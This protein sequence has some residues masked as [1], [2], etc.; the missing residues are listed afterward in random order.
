MD[1]DSAAWMAYIPSIRAMSPSQRVGLIGSILL[2][3]TLLIYSCTLH[4]RIRA[5]NR[6][7]WAPH[8][9]GQGMGRMQSGIISGRS[10]S[11]HKFDMGSG[12][13]A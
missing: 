4:R 9:G 5:K 8:G 3:I 11:G 7:V 1:N 10:R 2:C 6:F 13:L 12:L